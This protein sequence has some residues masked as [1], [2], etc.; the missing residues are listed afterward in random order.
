MTAAGIIAFALMILSISTP[1]EAVA[2]QSL[3]S[4]TWKTRVLVIFA[5]ADDGIAA[6]QKDILLDDRAG[7]SERDMLVLEVTGKNVE[8]LHGQASGLDAEALKRDLISDDFGFRVVLVGKD[9][10]VKLSERQ[11]V[12]RSAL[13]ALIDG[14]PMRRREQH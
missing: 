13:Y 2:V 9:G 7:L 10:T 14:M 8:V 5:G 11:P 12:S 1:R 6:R 4:Q 3:Q